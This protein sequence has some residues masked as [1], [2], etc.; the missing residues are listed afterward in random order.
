MVYITHVRF[1]G[2]GNG[3]EHIIML[4]WRAAMGDTNVQ[5]MIEWIEQGGVA[6]VSDGE[7]EERVEVVRVPGQRPYLQT[8]C[9]D[10]PTNRIVE[11]PQF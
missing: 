8:V 6:K 10:Q 1:D 2:E 7:R 4:R 3:P 9:D 5:D 11:L